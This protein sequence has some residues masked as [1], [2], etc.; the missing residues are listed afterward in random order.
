MKYRKQWSNSPRA[1]RLPTALLAFQLEGKAG[2][3][4]PSKFSWS[5]PELHP[6]GVG[7][8]V[9][10]VGVGV[11]LGVAVGVAVGPELVSR[12]KWLE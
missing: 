12:R 1:E 7:V 5:V 3:T 9:P 6:I 2:A 11:G 4:T 10:G 8:G